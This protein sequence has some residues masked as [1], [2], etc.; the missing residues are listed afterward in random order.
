MIEKDTQELWY[1]IEGDSSRFY[2]H[3]MDIIHVKHIHTI[4][5]K[6]ISPLDVLRRRPTTPES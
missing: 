2:V 5:Y 1:E 4:G 3:N 6:G